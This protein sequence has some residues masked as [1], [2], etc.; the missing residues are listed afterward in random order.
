MNNLS[1]RRQILSSVSS[2]GLLSLAG[3]SQQGTS[4]KSRSPTST[5]PQTT[6]RTFTQ[7]PS[8]PLI[9][10]ETIAS[11]IAAPV[12]VA[13]DP[14]SSVKY[15]AGKYGQILV[16]SSAGLHEKP[17]LDIGNRIVVGYET[18]L[19]GI[20]LH[21]NFPENNRIFVR[22]SS[23]N[24]EGTP[25]SYSHTFVLSEFKVSADGLRIDPQSE[26]VLLEIPEPQSNHNAGSIVFGP[27]GYLY[28]G[29][30]DGGGGGDQGQGHVSDWYA[31]VD[32]G[33]GQ[34]VNANLLG[35]LL[36]I[37]VDEKEANRGYGIPDSNPL[38]GQKGLDEHYAWGFRN[39]WRMSFDGSD[40]YVGD[41]GQ[42]KY[43]EVDFVT[44]GQNYGWNIKEGTHCYLQDTCPDKTP[45]S[46]RGGEPLIDP[47]IEY[48]HRGQPVHGTSVIGG[49]I[50]RG[51][52]IPALQGRYIFGD[53]EANGRLFVATP[54]SSGLWKTQVLSL[55]T[56]DQSKINRV[57]SFG[58]DPDD[59]LYVLGIGE[60]KGGLYRIKPP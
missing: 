53:L 48:P 43:E 2:L 30:G 20:A 37:D 44:K 59:E 31:P 36:R 7:L 13:F 49:Y 28:I 21:P 10:L 23:P 45:P 24:R 41:V 4:T 15:I 29:V 60:T 38:V 1:T 27:D 19:L 5:Q 17:A 16:H 42:N 22:Y 33:N 8:Q 35:S 26:Q 32:G 6:T 57:F 50:Y 34:D 14:Q 9:A 46:V 47:I 51:D 3:C 52:D 12:D 25:S 55:P 54:Q 56:A 11:G 58:R 18:G 40:L 39:P